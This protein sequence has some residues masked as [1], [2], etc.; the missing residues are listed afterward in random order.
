M[1]VVNV[2]VAVFLCLAVLFGVVCF[3][4][5]SVRVSYRN[6]LF[7]YAG[8]GP[9]SKK[10]VPSAPEKEKKKQK[11]KKKKPKK[12]SNSAKKKADGK[13][14]T[15]SESSG[16]TSGKDSGKMSVS[17]VLETVQ[18]VVGQVLD[19]FHKKAKIRID[20]LNV[21]VSRPDAADTAVQFGLSSGV[22]SAI[23]ALA[24]DFGKS[25]IKDENIS[26]VPDFIS[27]KSSIETDITLS[28]KV[29]HVAVLALK[30]LF[31]RS[32]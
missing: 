17:E 19:L 15:V 32:K 7:V 24:S 31:R 13:Q 4:P 8:I 26:V 9:F 28:V 3:L 10:L 1:T 29:C 11:K 30:M 16:K 18:Y 20:A 2:V 27:G 23:L 14:K 5:L 6:E 21:V 25:V 12:K 22:V